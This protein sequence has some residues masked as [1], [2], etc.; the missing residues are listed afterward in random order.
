MLDDSLPIR[1]EMMATRRRW[2]ISLVSMGG[3]LDIFD[4]VI[5]GLM[6]LC[7]TL[8]FV[9]SFGMKHASGG[10]SA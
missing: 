8:A 2:T 1:N 7:A 10:I 9:A 6:V 5:Y 3:A 4:L